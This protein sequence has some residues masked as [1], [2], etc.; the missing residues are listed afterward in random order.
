[1][2]SPVMR[3][4]G[5]I[6][7][8]LYLWHMIVIKKAPTPAFVASSFPLFAVYVTVLSVAIAVVMY[9][10]V[11]RPFLMLRPKLSSNPREKQRSSVDELLD[12][13]HEPTA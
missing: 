11:E 13:A 12:E 8:S 1:M 9:L 6:S 5:G 7:F 10:A 2:A 3:F 4:I